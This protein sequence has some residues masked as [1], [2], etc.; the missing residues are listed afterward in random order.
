MM[1]VDNY[2]Y[3]QMTQNDDYDYYDYDCSD[4]Y[5]GVKQ[6]VLYSRDHTGINLIIYHLSIHTS[7][8]MFIS[9]NYIYPSITL[10]II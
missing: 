8:Y 5:R 3:Y 4:H 6:A 1:I 7:I 9:M 2:S 10:H